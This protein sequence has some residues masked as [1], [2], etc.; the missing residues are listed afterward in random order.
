MCPVLN[1]LC[2]ISKNNIKNH[3]ILI[4]DISNL[5]ES[6]IPGYPNLEKLKNEI[7]KINKNYQFTISSNILICEAN[8]H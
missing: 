4:D 2:A 3:T 5:F 1:E 8:N 6:P 7:K